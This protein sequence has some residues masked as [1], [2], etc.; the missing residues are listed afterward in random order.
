MRTVVIGADGHIGTYLIPMLVDN[1]YETIAITRKMSQPYEDAPIRWSVSC[2]TVKR[3]PI[4][5]KS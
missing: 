4:S 5:S 1:G 2:L 3:T